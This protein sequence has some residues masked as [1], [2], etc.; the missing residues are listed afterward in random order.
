M[1]PVDLQ[2]LMIKNAK[3]QAFNVF[4]CFKKCRGSCDGDTGS[5]FFGKSINAGT[6]V[7][8]GNGFEFGIISDP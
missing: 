2:V 3:D 7:R 8:E 6:D 4:G 5:Q 1:L